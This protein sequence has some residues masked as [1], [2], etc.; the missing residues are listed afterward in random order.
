MRKIISYLNVI[1]R[2][3]RVIQQ[4]G[5]IAEKNGSAAWLE[6]IPNPENIDYG[7]NVFYESI[8]TT[9]LGYITYK[10]IMDWEIYIYFFTNRK[11]SKI[12]ETRMYYTMCWQ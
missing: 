3:I 2:F 12:L 11:Y 4:N 7:Y 9:L 10:Q 5:K 8:D 6:S 1:T